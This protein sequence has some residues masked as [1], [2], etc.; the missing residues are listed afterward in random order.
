V[1]GRSPPYPRWWRGVV[2]GRGPDDGR[3]WRNVRLFDLRRRRP[4]QPPRR[5]GHAMC[6]ARHVRRR[7]RRCWTGHAVGNP[8][9]LNLPSKISVRSL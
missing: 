6:A 7:G 1:A 2:L 8:D 3:Q 4:L 5:P 9:A